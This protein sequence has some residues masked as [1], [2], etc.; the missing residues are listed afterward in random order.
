MN[1]LRDIPGSRR[2]SPADIAIIAACGALCFAMLAMLFVVVL[3]T[4]GFRP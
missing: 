3:F 4:L 1:P 2:H